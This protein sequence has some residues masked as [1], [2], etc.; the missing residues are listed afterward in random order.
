M[1]FASAFVTLAV[2]NSQ[3][4][5]IYKHGWDTVAD[6]M[7]M[8]GKF[9]SPDALPSEDSIAFIANHYT[10]VTT[11]GGCP[12]KSKMTLEDGTL[13]VSTGIKKINPKVKV[14]MY[15]RTDFLLEIAECSNYTAE[16]H[17]HGTEWYLRLDNGSFAKK[18]SG[19]M[20]DYSNPVAADFFARALENVVKQV[21]G[22]R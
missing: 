4:A 10:Q 20:L 16:L 7:G 3:A 1:R 6:V 14:G 18:G 22:E 5:T 12:K 13:A 21:F 15:W 19:Y 11:G 8:H 2:A 9:S 17:A